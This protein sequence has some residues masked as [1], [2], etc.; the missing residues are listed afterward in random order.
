ME[1]KKYKVYSINS[2]GSIPCEN[3]RILLLAS[4]NISEVENFFNKLESRSQIF[5]NGFLSQDN[6]KPI[7]KE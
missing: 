2:L 6:Y 1:N 5:T 7:I 4:D 3:E